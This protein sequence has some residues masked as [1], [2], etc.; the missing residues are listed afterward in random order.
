MTL[1]WRKSSRSAGG[2]GNGGSGDCVEVALGPHGPLVRDSKTSE[3]G[4]VLHASPATF[5]ALLHSLKR[6]IG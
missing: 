6:P 5:A 3:S 1:N 2:S 4:E